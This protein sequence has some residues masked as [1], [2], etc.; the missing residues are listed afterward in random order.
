MRNSLRPFESRILQMKSSR[1]RTIVPAMQATA[2]NPVSRTLEALQEWLERE[3]S[4]GRSAI[5]I[6]PDT[7]RLLS[8]LPLLCMRRAEELRQEAPAAST[9]VSG[10]PAAPIAAAP[11]R[12]ASAPHEPR[13]H[14]VPAAPAPAANPASSEGGPI[15]IDG[16]TIAP[17]PGG[18]RTEEWAREQLRALY[19]EAKGCER[20][21]ALGT[22]RDTLVF[23][24]GNPCADILFVGEAPGAE[25]EKEKRPFVGPAGQKL[26]QILQ[27]MGLSREAVYI[28][29]IVK[30]RPKKGD[31][32]LQ[33]SSNRKPDATEMDASIRFV[34]AEIAVVAPRVI[35]ALGLTAAEGLL[36]RGG[37]ISGFRGTLHDFEGVPVV[38]TYHPSFLLRQESESDAERARSMKRRVW[39][40]MLRAMEAA[41]MPITEKQRGFFQC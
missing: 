33:G 15:E 37:T 6:R 13:P 30:Y 16:L 23:A 12:S 34:R 19:R 10:S 2:G 40:D 27:A 41:A 29:N 35:V 20:C 31:G 1:D 4:R 21:R 38:V 8:E 24:A 5:A 3:K 32:R 22:L 39:E 17:P 28:T 7:E 36:Q 26:N 11:Q 18:V 25:E 14:A 9:A